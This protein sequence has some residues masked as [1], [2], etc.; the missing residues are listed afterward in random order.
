MIFQGEPFDFLYKS[1]QFHEISLHLDDD[2]QIHDVKENQSFKSKGYNVM[3][4]ND[5]VNR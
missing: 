1:N 3:Y 5:D 2:D 4:V